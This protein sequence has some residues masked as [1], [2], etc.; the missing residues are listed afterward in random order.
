[1]MRKLYI[2]CLLLVPML[3]DAGP[4]DTKLKSKHRRV[5]ELAEFYF[6]ESNFIMSKKYYE[7][8]LENYPQEGYF[9]HKLGVA[10]L[11]LDDKQRAKD[12]L[13]RAVALDK[14][15]AHYHLAQ[16]LHR[17]E[18][19]N[20]AIAHYEIY[21]QLPDKRVTDARLN[22]EINRVKNAR[23]SYANPIAVS[24]G[25]VGEKINSN[26]KDY[27]PLINAEG[28]QLIFTSRRPGSTGG[29]LDP[30]DQP[31]ED[32]YMSH[33]LDDD[34]SEP[35][36]FGPPINSTY[37]DANVCFSTNGNSLILYRSEKNR[38]SG[39]LH[40]S[41]QVDT[42]WTDPERLPKTINTIYHE[43]SAALSPSGD[44]MYLVS[45]RPGSLGERDIFL[46]NKLPNGE[47]S[48]PNNLGR[49]I[50]T[51][52]NEDAPFV[53][54]TGTYLYFS[55]AGHNSIGG[56]DI[57]RSRI[58]DNGTVGPPVNMGYPIN[59]VEDD[60]YFSITADGK[61]AFYSSEKSTGGIGSQDIYE[62][63]FIFED[64]DHVIV[65]GFIKNEKGKFLEGEIEINDQEGNLV[66]WY[67]CDADKGKFV[68]PVL[69]DRAYVLR[70]ISDGYIEHQAI[71]QP[72]VKSK[73]EFTVLDLDIV[74]ARED[75]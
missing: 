9:H 5:Y 28:D 57:F 22:Y 42:G 70:A 24:I 10:H 4:G 43:P 26:Y 44:R 46:V 64:T 27:V 73:G 53:D 17:L 41:H 52:Y 48:E 31:Y 12:Y 18:K 32:I 58:L 63:D 40:I 29:M 74:L 14:K 65:K 59:T 1:M 16:C 13:N 20:E 6:A 30:N 2:I 47:W 23:Y 67:Y 54:P 39:D 71:I 66:E 19:F 35:T 25:N 34:W 3:L 7:E 36:Q 37:H 11:E 62:I 50:N 33:K 68:I 49:V 56:F 8:L 75:E 45:N 69:P 61:K 15:E 51:E 38:E 72:T 60:I 55:S 21:K